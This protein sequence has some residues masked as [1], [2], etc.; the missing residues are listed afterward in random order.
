MVNELLKLHGG[1]FTL[2]FQDVG[3]HVMD[4]IGHGKN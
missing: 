2:L 1:H 4:T 3:S